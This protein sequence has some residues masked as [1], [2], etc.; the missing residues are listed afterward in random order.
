MKKALAALLAIMLL[1]SLLTACGAKSSAPDM[2]YSAPAASAAPY[3]AADG[4]SYDYADKENSYA[5]EPI[6]EELGGTGVGFTGS[7]TAI[8]PSQKMIFTV[9]ADIETTKF[10]ESMNNVNALMTANGAYVES[11]YISG[12]NYSDTFYGY[13]TY[14]S[15]S[16]TIRVP[17]DRLDAMTNS[18]STIGNVLNSNKQSQNIT[19]QFIDTESRLKA[20][21]AEETSLLAMLEKAETVEVILT[22]QQRLSDV[23][24]EIESLTSMLKNWQNQVDYSTVVLTLRE[25][26]E[27][28]EPE[29][30][31]QRTYWD[32]IRDGFNATLKGIGEFFKGLF[33][34]I[35]IALP[36]LLILAVLAVAVIVII[37]LV[38]KRNRT[39]NNQ[40]TDSKE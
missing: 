35:V 25:V 2:L 1:V 7:G 24:Y 30:P 19:I 6:R 27:L 28:T 22:I 21:R 37:R 16:F 20:C 32:E 4:E 13:K 34:G 17:A 9:T 38:N 31:L 14:R 15:A 18:L 36:V 10:D 40:D 11:S 8:P 23:R 39:K 5:G 26:A 12:K 3:P 33:K 29:P